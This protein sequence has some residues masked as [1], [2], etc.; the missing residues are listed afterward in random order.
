MTQKGKFKVGINN[1]ISWGAA[2]VII[3]LMAKLQ[4]WPWGDWMI[5]VGLGTE[6]VLFFL[7]GFQREDDSPSV[8]TQMV[9]VNSGGAT[10]AAL[11]NMLKNAEV[12]PEMIGKLGEGL[13]SFGDKV[14]AISNV[15]DVSLAT[16]QFAATLKSATD[17]FNKLNASFEKATQ[18]LAGIGESST[19]ARNYQEQINKLAVNLQQLNTV[20]EQELQESDRK[21]K[22]ITQHYDSIAQTLKNFNESASD[23]QQLKEQ[24]N[25]LNKNLSSL[26]AVYGN[27]L[28]AMNQPRV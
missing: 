25:T 7:L 8:E 27:M 14:Q 15:S 17:G 18:D 22:A 21:L 12:N 3:G 6:A 20:Y 9:Q 16:N 1:I 11:D 13:K 26:N 2:V 4:H 10:T 28:A 23:T 5:V 19:D 24:I